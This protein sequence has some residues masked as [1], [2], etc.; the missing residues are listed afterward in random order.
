MEYGNIFNEINKDEA[1]KQSKE[2]KPTKE[3]FPVAYQIYRVV[4]KVKMGT[5]VHVREI[6]DTIMV[7]RGEVERAKNKAVGKAK[8]I[9]KCAVIEIC[10]RNVIAV[11]ESNHHANED[12]NFRE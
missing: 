8:N 10:E 5:P 4:K 2:V 7:E 12:D 3:Y 6:I 1:I 11:D 9:G